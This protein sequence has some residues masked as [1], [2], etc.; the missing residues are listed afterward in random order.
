M[1]FNK[2]VAKS[3]VFTMALSV[4]PFIAP[5]DVKAAAPTGVAF[6]G[7]K[8]TIKAGGNTTNYWGIATKEKKT[9]KK[10]KNTIHLKKDSAVYKV[11][12]LSVLT[13]NEGDLAKYK[14]K[15]VTV[16]IGTAAD[17]EDA[18]NWALTEIKGYDKKFKAFYSASKDKSKNLTEPTKAIGTDNDGY[19]VFFDKDGQMDAA[20]AKDNV[21]VKLGSGDWKPVSEYFDA[22][23]DSA[24]VGK[25]LSVLTQRGAKLSFRLKATGTSWGS[26]EV[27]VS[28][29]A[30]KKGPNVKLDF[31]KE[32]S[33]TNNKMEFETIVGDAKPT[34]TYTAL[35]GKDTFTTLEITNTGEGD[36]LKPQTILFRNKKTNKA[37]A[38]KDTK[39]VVKKQAKPTL[40]ENSNNVTGQT[41]DL[42][43]N[44]VGFDL[45]VKYDVKKGATLT[46]KDTAQDYE[47]AVS[48]DG[49][50]KNLK[51]VLLKK[52]KEA[53]NP[54]KLK[55]NASA[56]NK[57][58][59]F[60][61]AGGTSASKL[62]IRFPGEKQNKNNEL[63]LP[64]AAVEVALKPVKIEQ[65]MT[66]TSKDSL[67]GLTI[68]AASDVAFSLDAAKATEKSYA[69]A[70]KISNIQK[71]EGKPKFKVTK[72]LPNIKVT[73]DEF[74]ESGND[75]TFNINVEINEKAFANDPNSETL[76]F[77][78]SAEGM[79]NREY[80]IT[81]KKANS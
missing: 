37:L 65:A 72:S 79:E 42:I 46:N 74:T 24:K 32:I 15:D 2:T 69:I 31:V 16:A 61:T 66:I 59:S 39:I 29:P 68:A 71:K 36:G 5:N 49:T 47:V 22:A 3:L 50:G 38:S 56:T 21:E 58:G 81:F 64:S 62:F 6:D 18:G 17:F 77:T 28:I 7:A 73:V 11:K 78:V 60:S 40:K 80:T 27:K 23:M 4:M 53:E 10:I 70:A 44:K 67:A 57:V 52:A 51:W 9:P 19:L 48:W 35:K 25:K 14:G 1:K 30:Q 43:E 13:G 55:I 34:G 20:K 8:F 63:T 41:V 75:A 54:T 45:N 33:S 26:K 12:D 76:K